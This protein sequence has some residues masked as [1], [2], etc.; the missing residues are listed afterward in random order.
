TLIQPHQGKNNDR[1]I[2]LYGVIPIRVNDPKTRLTPVITAADEWEPQTVAKI[3]VSEENARAMT[4]TLAMVDEGLLGL[5]NYQTPN[6]R[7]HFYKKEALGVN[8]WDIFDQVAGAYGGELERLLALGGGDDADNKDQKDK[9]RFPPVVKFLGPFELAAGQKK[10]H[11]IK[12]PEYVG[13]VRVM[14]VAGKNSAYGLADKSVPIR[15]ALTMLPTVP[16]VL[17]PEEDVTIPVSIFTMDDSIKKVQLKIEAD[18]HFEV[19]GENPLTINFDKQGEQLGF[20]KLKVKAKLGQAH[21]GFTASSGKFKTTAN[22]NI[23]IRSA[24]PK[25]LRQI[26]KVI[27]PGEQWSETIVPHGLKNTNEVSLEIASVPPINLERRL[28]YLIRYPHGCVEQVTSSVFPQLYLA[29]LISLSDKQKQDIENNIHNAIDRLRGFQNSDGGF[30]YW[31]GNGQLNAWATN[32]AGHFFIEADKQ[33]Y[34]IPN[35]MQNNWITH[36]KNTARNWIA[37]T[38][39]SELEQAY[40]LYT[41]ALAGKAELGAMNRLRE[42]DK[43]NATTRWQLAA[44][45][46]LAGL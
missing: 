31:P 28:Q 24:N 34:Q 20:I 38:G 6:L 46:S 2:R 43:L 13:A 39:A 41:L 33:G 9:K 15:S 5:T 4:Y 29:G 1:P 11:E 26:S 27:K 44:T 19:I 37:G 21:L 17:G 23:N 32:Y 45:Y 18:D 40:R 30:M 10:S 35:E 14:L 42:S 36:Q 16:R 22:V 25:T 7:K 3:T 8:S 12:L